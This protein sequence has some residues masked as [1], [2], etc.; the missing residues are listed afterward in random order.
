MRKSRSIAILTLVLIV[1]GVGTFLY[2]RQEWVQN[3][4]I[5][6]VIKK[7][8]PSLPFKIQSYQLS[9]KRD[10]LKL[11]LLW[12]A[13]VITI[14]GKLNLKWHGNQFGW[15]VHYEPEIQVDDATALHFIL[16]LEAPTDFDQLKTLT[17]KSSE[18]PVDATFVW[19]A[20]GIDLQKPNL[21][22]NYAGESSKLSGTLRLASG[23]WVD[24]TNDQHAIS[25]TQP[26]L[27]AERQNDVLSAEFNASSSEVLWDALY[28][29]VPLKDLPLKVSTR[30]Q[31]QFDLSLGKNSELSA[32]VLLSE[33]EKG[34][35]Q[36]QWKTKNLSAAPI[37]RWV[38]KT[39]PSSWV[40]LEKWS[41]LEM[42]TG[43]LL[44]EG[45][46]EYD[47]VKGFALKDGRF[48]ASN[49]SLRSLKNNLTA[50]KL[51]FSIPYRDADAVH[52]GW[53]EVLDGYYKKISFQLKKTEWTWSPAEKQGFLKTKT[54]IPLTVAKI[55]LQF[56]KIEGTLGKTA[57]D[58]YQLKS[59]LK[60]DQANFDFLKTGLCLKPNQVPPAKW[61]VNF[62]EIDLTPGVIDPTGKIE[63]D[64]FNGKIVLNELGIFD[65]ASEVPEIDFDLEWSKIDLQAMGEWSKF[66][67]I[68]G[69]LEGYAH[70][71]VFQSFLPTQ[72]DFFI[73]TQS[74]NHFRKKAYTEFSPEAMKNVVKIF[75]GEDLDEQ[76]PGIAGWMMFGWPSR[77]FGGYDVQ[78]AGISVQ[79]ADGVIVVETLDPPELFEQT[80]KHFIL[81]GPRFKMPIRS[82]QYP[83][84]LDATAMSNFVHQMVTRFTSLKGDEQNETIDQCH[85]PEL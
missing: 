8:S 20:M 16:D 21:L 55:P 60:V 42:K 49:I 54:A 43:S 53:V 74:L 4:I 41:D 30:D 78:Y 18:Q 71:V 5:D 3:K 45:N 63:V 23:M 7:V 79:S 27:I 66:G 38:L 28:A 11:N 61:N 22:L 2:T 12:N 15:T 75:T 10:F 40:S 39:L 14:A 33:K 64:V 52:Q 72:Y 77:V 48:Q 68:K 83:L 47:S 76:I 51:S 44:T 56:G 35:T 25:L 62:T 17:F 1:V 81:Y 70:N 67:E 26:V 13:H 59:S 80:R 46:A 50:K 9:K 29:D 84:V 37:M 85:P 58:A 31:L 24:P 6:T 73:Q 32:K 36:Y 82:I 65:W 57:E 34:P 19:K 69:T